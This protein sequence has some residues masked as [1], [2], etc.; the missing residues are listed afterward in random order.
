MSGIAE[1]LLSM[2]YVVSGSDLARSETSERLQ[3]LGA[4]IFYGHDPSHVGEA[5]DVVVISS[6]VKFSNPEVAR[7][8]DLHVPV[9]PRAEMLAEL[10]R[11]KYGLAVAGTH[12]KTTTTSLLG[13]VLSGG[14]LDPTV[15][16]GGKVLSLGSNARL[17]GGEYMVVE[18]DES[19][20]TFLLLSPT[21]AI[22]TN[23]DP[24][25]LDHYGDVERAAD[26]FLE[27]V[28]RVP[29]YGASI[30]CVDSP[31]VRALLP[32]VRK[33]YVTY[34][35]SP[36][37][38]VSA[39]D[40]VVEGFSTRFVATRGGQDLGPVEIRMPGR[41]VAQNALATI[42]AGAEVGVPFASAARALAGFTGIHRRFEQRG[43]ARGVL[44]IDDYG[45]HPEEIRVT[46]R[47]AREALP[48]RRLVAFQPHRFTRTRDLFHDF[49]DAFDDADVLFLTEVY[50]AGE[51]PIEGATGT[52]LAH[53]L[54]ARGHADVRF[55]PDRT[56]LAE[57]LAEES[58]EGDVVLL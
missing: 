23:I 41:H 56:A 10:M 5:T 3:G 9:I 57:R 8:R 2:G 45:H 34:G 55:V 36:D 47:A 40:L 20:G 17:G 21:I 39:R 38:E 37:A 19:D 27:F 46:L 13:A 4:R 49:L 16:I 48:R 18:A 14:G 26:A 30:L 52:A 50:P 1:I 44:V 28:N 15:V 33:R 42:A 43:E 22:V 58:R 6:A 35:L 54:T 11:V 24:E 53:A 31:R 12:G 32:R 25:H 29:F 7:A 51:E